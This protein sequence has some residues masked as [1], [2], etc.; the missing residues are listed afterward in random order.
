M[1]HRAAE[2]ID[3]QVVLLRQHRKALVDFV[4][5]NRELKAVRLLHF[6]LLLDQIVQNLPQKFLLDFLRRGQRVDAMIIRRR[7]L[8]SV[9]LIASWL[10][11]AAMPSVLARA[12]AIGSISARVRTR[13]IIRMVV[14]LC[15]VETAI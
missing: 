7:S 10:T 4:L 6:Q 9:M 15:V 11:T 12:G 2:L 1:L 14:A 5:R 8:R 3:S 13:R